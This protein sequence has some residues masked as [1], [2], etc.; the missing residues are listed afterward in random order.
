MNVI[1]GGRTSF[2]V[3]LRF[4][5]VSQVKRFQH[6]QQG[7]GSSHILDK[8][9][10]YVLSLPLTTK[11]S[12]IYCNHRPALL[13]ATQASKLPWLTKIEAKLVGVATR[14]WTKMADSKSSIN[15]K[16][17][18]LVKQLLAKIPYQESCLQSFPS[19]SAMIREVNEESLHLV[20]LN[21]D[22]SPV[23]VQSE[24]ENLQIPSNQLSP[25]PLYHPS[26]QDPSTIIR[27]LH[28]FRD[29]SLHYHRKQAIL[30]AVGIPLT[31]PLVL[32][33]IVPNVP[34]FY[35]AYRVY[36]HIKALM[37]VRNLDYLLETPTKKDEE[38]TVADTTH[39]SFK[40]LS[41]IAKIYDQFAPKDAMAELKRDDDESMVIT[42]EVIDELADRLNL[43]SHVKEALTK[44]LHSETAR[45]KREIKVADQVE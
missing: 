14:I 7:S 24:V 41:E 27:Q 2:S 22:D 43:D 17:V 8:N 29:H 35:L 3:V 42:S 6:H 34:G 18:S 4:P 36:C 32:I 31:F 16:I 1:T 25:I 9:A 33:P 30:C 21:K 11:E 5:A 45:L 38:A 23:I 37:G 44:A 28:H 26:F 12:F 19:K 15:V 39:V 13:S 40:S 20:H 10:I